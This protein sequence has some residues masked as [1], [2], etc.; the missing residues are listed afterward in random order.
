MKFKKYFIT[1]KDGYSNCVIRSFCKIYN[2]EYDEVYNDLC[3]IQK[4]LNC[5][6]FN[7]IPVFETYMNRN[8][9]EA[10][11]YGEDIKIKDLELDNNSYI[12]FCCDKKDFYHMVTIINNT[13]YD[14]DDSSFDL[15]TIRIYK[16]Q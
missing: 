14:R 8:N 12:I 9:T 5:E 3:N 6:S 16:K 2:K 1:N 4:E 10:I 11:N 7:Y 15:Y 13:L